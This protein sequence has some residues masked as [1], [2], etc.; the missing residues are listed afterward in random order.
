MSTIIHVLFFANFQINNLS[1]KEI[2]KNFD[3]KKIV[4]IFDNIF[5]VNHE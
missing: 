1:D 4:T 2:V 3:D 5:I